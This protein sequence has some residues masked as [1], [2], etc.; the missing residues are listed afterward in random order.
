MKQEYKET[1]NQAIKDFDLPRY[2]EVPD[3]GFYL[4]QT[5]KY[6]NNVFAVVPNMEITSSMISNYV[7]KGIID[8]PNKKCYSRDQICYLMF[9]LIGKN[10]LSMENIQIL[11]EEQR[12][13]Y[14]AETAYEYLRA[15]LRNTLFYVSGLKDELQPI[16]VTNTDTK[17]LLR[18]TIMSVCYKIYL[19]LSIQAIKQEKAETSSKN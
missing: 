5:V 16:G 11:F 13:T 8:R 12:K 15:E 18:N 17:T 1:I 14:T 6:I 2:K 10:V 19:E 4:D 9:I 3:V 7:K